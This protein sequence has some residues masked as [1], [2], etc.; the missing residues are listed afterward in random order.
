MY[1]PLHGLGYNPASSP[2]LSFLSPTP[3]LSFAIPWSSPGSGLLGE[4]VASL[5]GGHRGRFCLALRLPSC[6]SLFCVPGLGYLRPEEG[7]PR[8][9]LLRA[10]RWVPCCVC[11]PPPPF[12]FSRL[13]PGW[14]RVGPGGDVTLPLAWRARSSP[15]IHGKPQRGL[16]SS[17]LGCGGAW[18]LLRWQLSSWRPGLG[19]VP[20]KQQSRRLWLILPPPSSSPVRGVVWFS[21]THFSEVIAWLRG[22]WCLRSLTR[23]CEGQTGSGGEGV[24]GGKVLLGVS[25]RGWSLASFRSFLYR[26]YLSSWEGPRISTEGIAS[27]PLKFSF[28]ARNPLYSNVVGLAYPYP[29]EPALCTRWQSRYLPSFSETCLLALLYEQRLEN[30]I[31]GGAD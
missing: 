15:C 13:P 17:S 31:C 22:N 19:W 11:V 8:G 4:G 7:A 10:F 14:L 25:L 30:M 26:C 1:P 28:W 21:G 16:A 2:F 12:P 27:V 3:T 29:L 5:Q 20:F 18:E 9:C 23:L 6:F 24:L